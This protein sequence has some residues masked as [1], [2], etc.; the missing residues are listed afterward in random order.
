LQKQLLC[1]GAEF[2]SAS[3]GL[4]LTGQLGQRQG[5]G[6]GKEKK[7]RHSCSIN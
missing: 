3:P 4:P 7:L 1:N 5:S 2:L 6:G